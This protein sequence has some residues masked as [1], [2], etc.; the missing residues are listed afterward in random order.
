M[1]LVETFTSTRNIYIILI[2]SDCNRTQHLLTLFYTLLQINRALQVADKA[3]HL[4]LLTANGTHRCS[5][6][7]LLFRHSQY[8]STSRLPFCE[9]GQQQQHIIACIYMCIYFSMALNISAQL[10]GNLLPKLVVSVN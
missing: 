2:G 6:K 1:I 3:L 7:G 9:T 10:S 5:H 8:A 4:N